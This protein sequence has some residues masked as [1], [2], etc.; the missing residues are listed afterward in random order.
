[1][2]SGQQ[3]LEETTAACREIAQGLGSANGG[4]Q[5][6]EDSVTEIVEKFEKVSGTFFFKTMPSVPATRTCRRDAA[7]LLDLRRSE[8]WDEF[9]PALTQMIANAQKLIEKAGMK[10]VTLT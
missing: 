8:R 3:F 4:S 7:A 1:M 9:G 5:V 10:G 6:W 2:Q